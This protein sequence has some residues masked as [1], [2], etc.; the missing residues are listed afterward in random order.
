MR[1][2]RFHRQLVLLACVELSCASFFFNR[3]MADSNSLTS[4]INEFEPGGKP[5]T[6]PVPLSSSI[7]T[8]SSK[9]V[10]LSSSYGKPFLQTSA[11]G[12]GD[13]FFLI[14]SPPNIDAILT[15]KTLGLLLQAVSGASNFQDALKIV[16]GIDPEKLIGET[17]STS[18]QLQFQVAY[19][20]G[21]YIKFLTVVVLVSPLKSGQALADREVIGSAY[22]MSVVNAQFPSLLTDLSNVE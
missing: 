19:S 4:S 10:S 11:K 22:R 12:K 6:P 9:I 7:D 17:N 5:S 13:R 14:K 18:A 3:A 20:T 1:T 2:T 8:G 16:E 15:C 21:E